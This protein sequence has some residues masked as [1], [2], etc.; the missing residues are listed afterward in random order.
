MSIDIFV[1]IF[2][3]LLDGDEL[4]VDLLAIHMVRKVKSS[5]FISYHP[6]S[7]FPSA[8]H[9]H[10]LMLLV[11]ESVYWQKIFSKCKDPT[12]LFLAILW[13]AIYAWD[14]SFELLYE[15]IRS[16]VRHSHAGLNRSG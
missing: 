14:E 5:T 8:N 3:L 13:Y 4:F 16:L 1:F 10:G 2:L 6:G 12:L 11:G 9:L 7:T 15:H